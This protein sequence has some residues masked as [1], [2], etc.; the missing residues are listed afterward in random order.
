MARP[1]SGVDWEL[2]KPGERIPTWQHVQVAVL[3]DL[4]D[5]LQIISRKLSALEC[6]N[7]IAIP[8]KLDAIRKNTAKPL[9]RAAKKGGSK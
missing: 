6:R 7:F 8:S 5:Q 3:M 1:F 9:K 4:R 2:V